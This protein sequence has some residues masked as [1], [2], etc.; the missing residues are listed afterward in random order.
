M[1]SRVRTS[2]EAIKALVPLHP[3]KNGAQE[4]ACCSLMLIACTVLVSALL[5]VH[6]WRLQGA[7]PAAE[8]ASPR[9]VAGAFEAPL[10]AVLR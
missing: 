4:T 5:L 8:T 7:E 10:F 3:A 1:G 2:S 9:T 6:A